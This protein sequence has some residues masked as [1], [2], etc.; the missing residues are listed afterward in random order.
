LLLHFELHKA[1][2]MGVF[3]ISLLFGVICKGMGIDA[4]AVLLLLRWVLG[5]ISGNAT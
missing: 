4:S 3:L 1:G 5:V 2:W